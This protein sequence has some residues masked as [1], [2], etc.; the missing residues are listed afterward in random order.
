MPG[1]MSIKESSMRTAVFVFIAVVFSS[2]FLFK[3]YKRKAFA[4]NQNGQPQTL[5]LLVPKGFSKEEVKDTAGIRLHSFQYPGGALLYAAYLTDT[6]YELQPF[7]KTAHQP[8][9]MGTKGMVYKGQNADLSF[10]REVCQGHL[11]FGYSGVPEERETYFD[12]ATNY[13]AMGRR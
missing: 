13:A 12:S 6:A 10:Y 4:Y 5:S 1:G 2:C 3:D 7:D 8:K 11:R 9:P